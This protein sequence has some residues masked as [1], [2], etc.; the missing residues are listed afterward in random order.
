MRTNATV[1]PL[2]AS[3]HKEAILA[4]ENAASAN[5]CGPSRAAFLRLASACLHG[6]APQGAFLY[7]QKRG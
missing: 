2:A 4:A 3:Q 5:E 1:P 7:P 6:S